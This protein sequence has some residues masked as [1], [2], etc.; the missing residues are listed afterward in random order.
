[1]TPSLDRR[2]LF[3][4]GTATAGGIAAAALSAPA[5]ATPA[6]GGGKGH[7]KGRGKG[8][9]DRPLIG[10]ARRD[11]LHVMAFNIRYDNS[12]T[13]G[14]GEPDH[15]PDR[16]PILIDLLERE[17]PTILG[18]QEALRARSPSRA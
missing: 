8:G 10:R 15:W 7:G 5:V 11:R 18:V 6:E 14:P 17:E 13:T 9:R 3:S 2:T 12:A 1:M 4:L 16:R